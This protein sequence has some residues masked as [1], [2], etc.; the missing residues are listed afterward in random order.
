MSC[1][2]YINQ[3]HKR[4]GAWRQEGSLGCDWG[5]S[6]NGTCICKVGYDGPSCEDLTEFHTTAWSICD[7]PCGGQPSFRRSFRPLS[8]YF[9][10]VRP[11][12]RAVSSLNLED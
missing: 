7:G 10:P 5:R 6:G 11:G 9:G 2:C 12:F 4:A 3:V 8:T 1:T